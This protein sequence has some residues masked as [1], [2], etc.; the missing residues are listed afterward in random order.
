MSAPVDVLAVMDGAIETYKHL[1]R[2]ARSEEDHLLDIEDAQAARAEVADLIEAIQQERSVGHR[3]YSA[4]AAARERTNAAL[5]RV[6][7]GAA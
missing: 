6:K 5:A 7:G 1:N 2:E 3:E 4:L